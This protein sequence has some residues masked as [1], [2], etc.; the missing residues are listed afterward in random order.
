MFEVQAKSKQ[1]KI[2]A[3]GYILL[4][5]MPFK[6]S[7]WWLLSTAQPTQ[8]NSHTTMGQHA[9]KRRKSQHTS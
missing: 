7:N 3:N 9:R 2:Q 4:F 6:N 5:L 8:E 1:Q